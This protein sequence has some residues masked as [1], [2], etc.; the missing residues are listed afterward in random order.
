MLNEFGV[1]CDMRVASAHRAPDLVA[2][3]AETAA[4]RGIRVIIAAAGGAARLAVVRQGAPR[5]PRRTIRPYPM[6]LGTSRPAAMCGESSRMGVLAPAAI[7]DRLGSMNDQRWEPGLV[8]LDRRGRRPR[9]GSL[10]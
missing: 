5:R 6:T 10:T 4:G 7:A 2:R 1:P 8:L 9:A 3:Y